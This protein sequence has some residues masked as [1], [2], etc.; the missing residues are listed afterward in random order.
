MPQTARSSNGVDLILARMEGFNYLGL[1]NIVLLFFALMGGYW[2]AG[3]LNSLLVQLSK[4]RGLALAFLLLLILAISNNISI[5]PW[6]MHIP[7]P[8]KA[9]GLLGIVRASGRLFWPIWYALVLS[10]IYLVCRTYSRK[11][12]WA[13]LFLAVGLQVYDTH[14]GW[15]SLHKLG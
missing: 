10:F 2:R 3:A 15:K 6:N 9:Y 4:Y 8:E 1:G 14:P 11:S 12:A 13:I 7:L 5:G